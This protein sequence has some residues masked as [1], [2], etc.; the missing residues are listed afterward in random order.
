MAPPKLPGTPNVP[1][2]NQEV[3][4]VSSPAKKI[5]LPSDGWDSISWSTSPAQ[6][7]VQLSMKPALDETHQE[8]SYDDKSD[9]HK[10]NNY[11]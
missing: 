6:R 11:I 3:R 1:T 8:T 5:K 9:A 4:Q 7:S 2:S 10:S